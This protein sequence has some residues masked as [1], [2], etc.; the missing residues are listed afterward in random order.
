MKLIEFKAWLETTRTGNGQKYAPNTKSTKVSELL[1]LEKEYGDLD[2]HYETDKFASILQSLEYSKADE[3][4][5]RANPAKFAV[6]GN[7]YNSLSSYRSALTGYYAIFLNEISKKRNSYVLKVNLPVSETRILGRTHIPIDSVKNLKNFDSLAAGD[8]IFVW[9]NENPRSS[10]FTKGS[11]LLAVGAFCGMGNADVPTIEIDVPLQAQ[12]ERLNT[13]QLDRWRNSSVPFEKELCEKLLEYSL[14][15]LV[16]IS[17]DAAAYLRGFFDID[18]HQ[19]NVMAETKKM[20]LIQP[21]NL[22]LHG[23]PGT[24]KTYAT[25]RI[26]VEMCGELAPD[27]RGD[28]MAAYHRLCEAGRIEFVTFHQSFA[29]EDFVEGLRPEQ[30]EGGA[31]F[32]L[33]PKDGVLKR[34]AAK[35]S[36]I[37]TRNVE[38]GFDITGRQIFKMSL[39][40]AYGDDSDIYDECIDE[41]CVM[42]AWGG[43]IDWSGPEFTTIPAFIRKWQT[44]VPSATH[45]DANVR[46]TFTLRTWMKEG[47]LIVISEGNLKF[48]AI[49]EVVGPYQFVRREEDGYNHRRAVRWLWQAEKSEPCT[50]LLED[51]T[52]SQLS[53][54][55]MVDKSVG[56]MMI[57]KSGVKLAALQDL[58]TPATTANSAPLPHV[59]I[60]DEINRANVSKTFGE[61]I[62]L[63]EDDKRL[64]AQN[65]LKVRLPY[66]GESFG[67][68]Q[69][70]HVLGTMNTADRSIALLDTALRRR[71][72]FQEIVPEPE[73]LTATVDGISV[74][75][76][77][78]GLNQRIEWLYDRDHLIGHAWLMGGDSDETLSARFQ[79]KIIPL[80]QEYFHENWDNV[81][82]ALGETA[83]SAY[84]VSKTLLTAPAGFEGAS[85]RYH[86]K[87]LSG[88]YGGAAWAQVAGIVAP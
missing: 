48:R 4:E 61:L 51:K 65:Q 8:E 59:L 16:A 62:T 36:A 40:A 73:V 33:E 31:G 77:L 17:S 71:F 19:K 69:N 10:E 22:I 21:L 20:A 64:G 79:T 29:Y 27:D 25:A 7:L 75:A 6:D 34:I 87:V 83:G 84:F 32:K 72:D 49:A 35:A 82:A 11:G 55:N 80:L 67:L 58:L 74:S 81:R 37:A 68:P 5:N 42:L 2:K 14:P 38:A 39:G 15:R 24:G 41:N 52:F 9:H 30:I 26:A 78:R 88:P 3:R 18:A 66:S 85:E 43:D 53:L 50:L 1:R 60:I 23:P 13:G 76:I 86:Y 70:L 56:G 57:N 12:T 46:Q 45:A 28:L 47:D 63:L 44:V 54:Y